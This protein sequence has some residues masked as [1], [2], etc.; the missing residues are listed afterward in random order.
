MLI[1]NVA[2]LRHPLYS[3]LGVLQLC[4]YLWAGFGFVFRERMQGVRFALLAYFVL[5]MNFAY[6]LGLFRS[7]TGHEQAIWQRIS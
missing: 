5:A 3:A 4:F 2:L 7:L 6:L 1:G